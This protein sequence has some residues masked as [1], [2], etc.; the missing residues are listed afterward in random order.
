MLREIV[1]KAPWENAFE[2]I[3]IPQCWTVFQDTETGN[4]QTSEVKQVGQKV[5]LAEHGS[6]SRA[7]A[8]SVW[9]LEV[10]LSRETLLLS[11]TT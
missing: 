6:S 4:S 1:R 8:E 2:D 3:G 7:E 11:T 5:G 9:P 10:Q